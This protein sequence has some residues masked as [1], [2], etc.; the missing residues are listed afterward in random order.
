M[1]TEG[2]RQLQVHEAALEQAR[3]GHSR[4]WD[5]VAAPVQPP[6]SALQLSV[7]LFCCSVSVVLAALD[8]G[9]STDIAVSLLCLLV[10]HEGL[11]FGSH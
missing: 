4:L 2:S 10:H 1:H 6:W 7:L 8:F 11:C 9:A 3:A 5:A